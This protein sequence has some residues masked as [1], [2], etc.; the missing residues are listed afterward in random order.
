MNAP[1]THVLLDATITAHADRLEQQVIQWRRHI[2][3][4]P[5]LGNREFETAKLVAAH[6]KK[7]GFDQVTEKVAYTGVVG[8]LKGG[9]PG[10]CVALRADMDALPVTEE[11]D[12][13]FKSVVRTLWNGAEAGVMHA[14]GHDTHVAMLMGV[15]EI[16]SSMRSE[17]QGTVKFIFQLGEEKLPG[18][19]SLMQ[20]AR[21]LLKVGR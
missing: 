9:K 3:A 12:I 13:P 17:L 15:A 21:G 11:T 6:L 19:A 1:D 18:G 20:H 16:L 10:P 8:V 2:H 7:L 5:E 4:N 14:C